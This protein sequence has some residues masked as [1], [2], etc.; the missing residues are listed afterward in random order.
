[1]QH[2]FRQLGSPMRRRELLK[3]VGLAA[4]A[5]AAPNRD[6]LPRLLTRLR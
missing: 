5:T 6:S 3:N 1:M 4:V 2:V